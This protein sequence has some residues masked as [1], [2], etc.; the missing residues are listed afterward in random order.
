MTLGIQFAIIRLVVISLTVLAQIYLF[1]RIRHAIKSSHRSNYF[2]SRTICLIGTIIGLFFVLNGYILTKPIS[3]DR[4]AVGG[5]DLPF[6]PP[7]HLDFRIYFLRSV[8]FPHTVRWQTW[9]DD[10]STLS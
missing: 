2:K 1:V 9:A 8:P 7:G 6:L 10:Y 5:T 4:P 3:L